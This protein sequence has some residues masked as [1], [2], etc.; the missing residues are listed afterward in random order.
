MESPINADSEDLV[1]L[2]N[3]ISNDSKYKKKFFVVLSILIVVSAILV[4]GSILLLINTGMKK[5]N[6][7]KKE[8]QTDKPTDKP[9]DEPT[10][11]PTDHPTDQPTDEPPSPPVDLDYIALPNNEV[12][13]NCLCQAKENEINAKFMGNLWNT[14]PRGT[15]RW[16]EGFQDMN[17]LVGYAQLKYNE[18]K[19]QCTVFVFTKTA[20]DLNLT[21]EF[22]GEEQ[23]SESKTFDSSFKNILKIKVK[24][25]TGEQLELEDVDF[26]WNSGPLKTPKFDTKGQRGAIVEMYGWKDTDIE[27]E[28]EFIGEQGYMGVKVFPHQEQV[29]TQ[30]PIREEMNPI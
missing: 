4:V 19:T 24:A 10:D 25:K 21:Y 12:Y 13:E 17:V 26:V 14:P 18:D 30:T 28:C 8:E 22:N 16:K 20:V 23:E 9:S 11:K 7:T 15:K 5:D 29:L 1:E 6:T 2:E 27:K 3:A